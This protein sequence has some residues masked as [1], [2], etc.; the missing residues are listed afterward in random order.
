MHD[1]NFSSFVAPN[2]FIS[3][4]AAIALVTIE[5]QLG[6]TSVAL[7][8]PCRMISEF[9]PALDLLTLLHLCLLVSIKSHTFLS[10][11]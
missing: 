9:E 10:L 7:V 4:F 2:N 8:W 1:Q 6:P 3:Y 11:A 5:L